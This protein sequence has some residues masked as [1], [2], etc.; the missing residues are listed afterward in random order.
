MRKLNVEE[1]DPSNAWHKLVK[2]VN[3]N[4]I[5]QVDILKILYA[6]GNTIL[7]FYYTEG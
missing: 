3:E 1:F 7:L 4:N 6:S 5:Q 2:F